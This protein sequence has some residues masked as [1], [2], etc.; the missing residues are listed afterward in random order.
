[1]QGV[2]GDHSDEDFCAIENIEISLDRLNTTSPLFGE[3]YVV[4]HVSGIFGTA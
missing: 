3:L 4:Q 2:D 1:M